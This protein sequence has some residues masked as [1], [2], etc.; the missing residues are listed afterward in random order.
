MV[1]SL[2]INIATDLDRD[3]LKVVLAL[4]GEDPDAPVRCMP[5]ATNLRD[6][7][8]TID[9]VWKLTQSGHVPRPDDPIW[10]ECRQLLHLSQADKLDEEQMTSLMQASGMLPP[11]PP[12]IDPNK[13][14]ESGNLR[15]PPVAPKTPGA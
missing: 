1:N 10:N 14:D 15:K 5:D 12:Q 7:V 2:A 3:L 9:G 11:P 13:V 4:M 8:E 6:A